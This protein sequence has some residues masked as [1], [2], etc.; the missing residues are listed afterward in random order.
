M[1]DCRWDEDES[2]VSGPATVHRYI[3]HY[4]L[5]DGTIEMRE[6]ADI[7]GGEKREQKDGCVDRRRAYF[8]SGKQGRD[9]QQGRVP[10]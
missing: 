7:K 10:P 9:K 8:R 1:N 5:E 4:F 2:V 3:L 6:L